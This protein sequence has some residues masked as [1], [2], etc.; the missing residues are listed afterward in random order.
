MPRFDLD[1]YVDVQTRIGQFWELYPDGAIITELMSDP[2]DFTQCRYKA[3]VYRHR[4]DARPSAVDFAF[5]IA[6]GPG[7]NQTSH[8][9]N[10]STSA[11]GRALADL[12]LA[13]TRED[14]PSRQEMAKVNREPVPMRPIAHQ[15]IADEG[16]GASPAM[17]G[18]GQVKAITGLWDR[19]GRPQEKIGPFLF[20]QFAQN[21]PAAL[22]Q[23]EAGK[24][25]VLLDKEARIERAVKAG[26]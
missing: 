13:K 26:A 6:G 4:D 18:V 15:S 16:D 21:D 24:V 5:E 17:A 25:I 22:T 20:E 7:A 10:C 1:R 8:E 12:G 3:S 19:L 14:R 11:V 9:E 23:E 2:N